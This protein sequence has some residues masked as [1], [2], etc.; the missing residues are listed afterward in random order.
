MPWLS[1]LMA[2]FWLLPDLTA[3]F[4]SGMLTV[5]RR[6]IGWELKVDGS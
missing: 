4:G 6:F 2:D 3:P 1:V 5:D